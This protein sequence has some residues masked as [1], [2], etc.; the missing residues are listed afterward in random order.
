MKKTL[1]RLRDRRES[2]AARCIRAMHGG[3]FESAI[4]ENDEF[5]RLT[6]EMLEEGHDPAVNITECRSFLRQQT[7]AG[8]LGSVVRT[9]VEEGEPAAR[10]S[11]QELL[12][13][14][15]LGEAA[16]LSIKQACEDLFCHGRA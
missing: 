1:K 6:A 12:A 3:Y 14:Q 13:E 11:L 9:M 5:Y 16:N 2:V 10:A 15:D 7:I 8:I 4:V